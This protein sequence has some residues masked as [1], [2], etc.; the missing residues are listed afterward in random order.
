MLRGLNNNNSSNRCQPPPP[1]ELLAGLTAG[2]LIMM[3]CRTAA[4]A[5]QHNKVGHPNHP[6]QS[7]SSRHAC[8]F[9]TCTVV[10]VTAAWLTA[11]AC[12]T[13]SKEL[14]SSSWRRQ[15]T[16]SHRSQRCVAVQPKQQ[17]R[18]RSGPSSRCWPGQQQEHQQQPTEAAGRGSSSITCWQEGRCR[19]AAGCPA[20]GSSS[21]A[22]GAAAATTAAAGAAARSQCY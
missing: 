8:G 1:R 3:H 20:D 9:C 12:R 14:A 6:M 15:Q 16:C 2:S 19:A 4:S 7:V 5:Q 10:E 11:C 22:Q 21:G 17:Q 13:C 18:Q